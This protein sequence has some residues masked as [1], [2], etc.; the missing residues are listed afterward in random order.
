MKTIN[1]YKDQILQKINSGEVTIDLLL[2]TK[3]HTKNSNWNSA[4]KEL[5]KDIINNTISKAYSDLYQQSY[6]PSSSQSRKVAAANAARKSSSSIKKGIS[7][8]PKIP[9]PI[10]LEKAREFGKSTARKKDAHK[11]M[12]ID[13]GIAGDREENKSMR[14]RQSWRNRKHD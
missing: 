13:E 6:V 9:P 12:Y 8:S 14:E 3:P 5:Q 10:N 2:E 1:E 7:S 4:L 11:K